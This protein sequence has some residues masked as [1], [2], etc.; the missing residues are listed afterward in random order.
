MTDPKTIAD[1]AFDLYEN[2]CTE[3]DAQD[4]VLPGWSTLTLDQRAHWKTK[5][6]TVVDKG[7]FVLGSGWVERGI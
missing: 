2:E 6:Q 1:L 4:V 5:A 3:A 7:D